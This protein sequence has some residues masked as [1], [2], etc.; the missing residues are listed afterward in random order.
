MSS[1]LIPGTV[2]LL[3]SHLSLLLHFTWVSCQAD[4]FGINSCTF[5]FGWPHRINFPQSRGKIF[6]PN[7]IRINYSLKEEQITNF[8]RNNLGKCYH[9]FSKWMCFSTIFF[10][11]R[12][13]MKKLHT[14]LV[15]VNTPFS[16]F[17]TMFLSFSRAHVKITLFSISALHL[18]SPSLC[19]RVSD[20]QSW[21]GFYCTE[22]FLHHCFQW[23]L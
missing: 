4:F 7:S 13:L 5:S 19:R 2:K 21:W 23:L 18:F 10:F 6:S 1:I 20:W 15:P 16:I 11:S 3:I 8:L 12:E 17:S 9:I 22:M 14:I